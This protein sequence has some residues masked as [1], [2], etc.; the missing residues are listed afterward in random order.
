MQEEERLLILYEVKNMKKI[1]TVREFNENGRITKETITETTDGDLG[2]TQPCTPYIYSI[3]PT[4]PV[5]PYWYK[6]GLGG[7]QTGTKSL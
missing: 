1:T 3:T 2:E 7:Y 5:T 4:T 6:I